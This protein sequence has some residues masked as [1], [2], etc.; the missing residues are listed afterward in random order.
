MKRPALLAPN[1]ALHG[2]AGTVAVAQAAGRDFELHELQ[3]PEPVADEILVEVHAVGMCHADLAA[4]D[5]D[6]PVPLPAVLGHEGAG[7]VAAVGPQAQRLRVG[8]RVVLSFDA[9][10]EC[11]AC[12]TGRSTRCAHYMHLNFGATNAQGPRREL[13]AAAGNLFSGFFGQS[14]FGSHALVRERSAVLVR[15]DL[16]AD[17][18][19]PLG[20][21][22]QTGVGAVLT[23]ARPRPGA[24]VA[25]S[26]LGPVGMSAVMAASNLSAARDIIAIDVDLGRLRL[27]RELGATE[28]IDATQQNLDAFGQADVVIECSGAPT[29]VAS[30]LAGLRTGGTLVLVGAP[31]FGTTHA[32]DIADIVNRSLTVRGTVE[33]DSQPPEMIPWLVSMIERGRLDVSKISRT[34]SLANINQAANDMMHRR[35]LKPVLVP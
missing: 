30:G 15:T 29:A 8:D 17:V 35:V 5:G 1:R 28:L 32:V 6:F 18:L 9:C 2:R 14:S 34:Y 3:F 25:V 24:V 10:G 21:A 13:H 16:P 27:A 22:V 12:A 33:G 23:V 31:R 11:R 19:A 4:R 26:G 7:V 20:C